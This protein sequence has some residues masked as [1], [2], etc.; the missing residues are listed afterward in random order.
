MTVADSAKRALEPYD[1][2]S[3]PEAAGSLDP[4]L[5]HLADLHASLRQLVALADD[6]LTAMRSADA[7]AL[8]DCAL[9][10]EEL[11]KR[12][13][14]EQQNR[15]AL[16][17]R[18]AQGL[19]QAPPGTKQLKDLLPHVPEPLS[20]ALQARRAALQQA[21]SELR[22]KNRIVATVAQNL[23]AHI[24]GVFAE[25]AKTAEESV[26]YGAGGQHE[27]STKRCWVDAVG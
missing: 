16:I 23:Q 22:R 11:V 18:A 4:L 20:S 26:V 6:K 10:E 21:A 13:L 14:F 3:L 24:R 8:R 19:P 5:R 25:L 17:T 9:R 27:T 15:G 7:T 12:V 1:W 2:P